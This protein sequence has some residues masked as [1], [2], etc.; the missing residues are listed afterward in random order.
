MSRLLSRVGTSALKY[1]FDLIVHSL[2]MSIP[3]TTPMCVKWTRGPRTATNQPATG[4]NG[5]YTWPASKPMQL[6]ATMYAKRNKF[7]S[8]MSK[9]TVKQVI[10]QEMKTVGTAE[11]D[12]ADFCAE[13]EISKQVTLR[14]QKCSDKKAFI[15]CTVRSRWL[16]QLADVGDEDME[17]SVLSVDA[18]SES[19]MPNRY[20]NE[21]SSTHDIANL[22]DLDGMDEAMDEPSSIRRSDSGSPAT[23][24]QARSDSLSRNHSATSPPPATTS[25]E[26]ATL[27]QQVASLQ[28][29]LGETKAENAKLQ[30]A[31]QQLDRLQTNHATLQKEY[32]AA[33][34]R[35]DATIIELRTNLKTAQS[36]LETSNAALAAAQKQLAQLM[37]EQAK[38][39]ARLKTQQSDVSSVDAH[40]EAGNDGAASREQVLQNEIKQLR[41]ELTSSQAALTES[42]SKMS[43][44]E[45]RLRDQAASHAS[46]LAVKDEALEA[47]ERARRSLEQERNAT[48]EQFAQRAAALQ[49]SHDK[50]KELRVEHEALKQSML[51]EIQ[52]REAAD[53]S[54]EEAEQRV[55]ELTTELKKLQMSSQAELKSVQNELDEVRKQIPQ[56]TPES[57]SA[58]MAEQSDGEASTSTSTAPSTNVKLNPDELLHKLSSSEEERL[59]LEEEVARLDAQIQKFKEDELTS[60]EERYEETFKFKRMLKEKDHEVEA[61]ATSVKEKDREVREMRMKL[62]TANKEL[63]SSSASIASH[64]QAIEVLEARLRTFADELKQVKADLTTEQEQRQQMEAQVKTLTDEKEQISNRLSEREAEVDL[65][66]KQR[67]ELEAQ[68]TKARETLQSTAVDKADG[69]ASE[70]L[71]AQETLREARARL[72]ELEQMEEKY[73]ALQKREQSWKESESTLHRKLAD[74]ERA[75]SSSEEEV[76]LLREKLSSE[77][78]RAADRESEES[79]ARL[80]ALQASSELRQ[81]LAA[82]QTA[83]DESRGKVD[84]LQQQCTEKQSKMSEQQDRIQAMTRAH[85]A[86]ARDLAESREQVQVANT[87]VEALTEQLTETQVRSENARLEHA[88]ER[89]ALQ[90]QLDQLTARRMIFDTIQAD[91]LAAAKKALS[92]KAQAGLATLDALRQKIQFYESELVVADETMIA[93]KQSTQATNVVLQQQVEHLEKVVERL[94]A[95]L[96]SVRETLGVDAARAATSES[97]RQKAEKDKA[98]LS[99]LMSRFEVDLTTKKIELAAA[100]DRL[101]TQ[102]YETEALKA[103]LSKQLKL[104]EAH[105]AE[106]D[107]L[108]GLT[109]R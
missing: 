61:I 55:Q 101:T 41:A 46:E 65:L 88:S 31:Q 4:K 84:A 38:L 109:D 77:R 87:K 20:S 81:Q 100:L 28:A 73:I 91:Q 102:E 45:T 25:P 74:A 10:N 83:L 62:D 15:R 53:K 30:L 63:R 80:H 50:E 13:Q 75:L 39:Q 44:L 24:G 36:E 71:Q 58:T 37:Q 99:E 21:I 32:E 3:L 89:S 16:K 97:K 18:R 49:E 103:Q 7:Q 35:A 27:K 85:D 96:A 2:H 40:V 22:H 82:L 9:I 60:L 33:E 26:V 94:K 51:H 105:S 47:A 8:K 95:E 76:H 67:S 106:L 29:E 48:S 1:Q 23:V 78:A 6:V 17:I 70:L 42:E 19:A 64:K 72:H 93:F 11:L 68:F 56:S 107:R 34:R 52:K 5:Q 69:D 14:L 57:A 43:S 98:K 108:R 92:D 54:V 66:R 104:C 79:T 12:L 59:K 90:R 86:L